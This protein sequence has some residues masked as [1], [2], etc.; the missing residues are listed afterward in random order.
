MQLVVGLS[1]LLLLISTTYG[2]EKTQ[3]SS[4]IVANVFSTIAFIDAQLT[5]NYTNKVAT[6]NVTGT[7][8]NNASYTATTFTVPQCRLKRDLVVVSGSNVD[9]VNVG[10]QVTNLVPGNS[11]SAYYVIEGH[12]FDS[13]NF[14]ALKPGS[15][16]TTFA[17]SG[18]MVVITVI[19]SVAM[20][21]LIVG[22]IVVIALGGR[23]K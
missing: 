12:T 17:R 7:F 5:C 18:G 19:L 9:T 10:Y 14:M 16:E 4:G 15:P 11:Y 13:V 23:S 3:L 21:L 6:L 2:Q 22:I 8:S 1:A 20:F